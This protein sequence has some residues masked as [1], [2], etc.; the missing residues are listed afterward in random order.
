MAGGG[1][2]PPLN[3]AE[4]GSVLSLFM[5]VVELSAICAAVAPRGAEARTRVPPMYRRNGAALVTVPLSVTAPWAV[6]P[7]AASATPIHNILVTLLA[8]RYAAHMLASILPL[9]KQ[10]SR[11]ARV[12]RSLDCQQAALHLK[13][14]LVNICPMSNTV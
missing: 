3:V 13:S 2:C 14:P 10:I 5:A 7:S 12:H 6:V 11:I 8:L 9:T 1:D 4:T